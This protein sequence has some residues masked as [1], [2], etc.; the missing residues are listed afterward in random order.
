MV[1]FV[2]SPGPGIFAVIGEN[3][4]GGTRS[5]VLM[6]LG[7]T[8][9]DLTYLLG[10]IYGLGS[11]A[12]A[13]PEMFIIIRYLGGA[14][15]MYLGIKA[16]RGPK[17][18]VMG[19]DMTAAPAAHGRAFVSGFLISFSNPKVMVFYLALLPSFMDIET[20]TLQDVITVVMINATVIILVNLFY[21][22]VSGGLAARL[23]SSGARQIFNRVSGGFLILAAL[24][25]VVS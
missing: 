3:L 21:I 20:L 19:A 23:T 12:T 10:A 8:L 2:A 6:M 15:L 4:M 22:R 14:W 16:W 9:S 7:I 1:I 17:S 24:Y 13:Y 11:M 18:V 5:A 25:M